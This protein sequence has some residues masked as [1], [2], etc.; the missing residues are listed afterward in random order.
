MHEPICVLACEEG[1]LTIVLQL[2][3]STFLLKQH[4]SCTCHFH[5][6]LECYIYCLLNSFRFLLSHQ[7]ICQHEVAFFMACNNLKNTILMCQILSSL[8]LIISIEGCY[9]FFSKTPLLGSFTLQILNKCVWIF[10]SARYSQ[11]IVN[12][13]HS[14]I[15]TKLTLQSWTSRWR[16][17]EVLDTDVSLLKKPLKSSFP[18]FSLREYVLLICILKGNSKL[19]EQL[20]QD[21]FPIS[22]LQSEIS[23]EIRAHLNCISETGE[24]K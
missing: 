7:L 19:N 6:R 12:S 8:S 13:I 22:L 3:Y 15:M 11:S 2:E 1:S 9:P 5:H 10:Q 23:I 21:S 20:I 17:L 18:H 16:I 4:T 14:K 24:A